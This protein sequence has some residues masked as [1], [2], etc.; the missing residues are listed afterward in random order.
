MPSSAAGP[1]AAGPTSSSSGLLHSRR[2]KGP[3]GMS[4]PNSISDLASMTQPFHLE[5]LTDSDGYDLYPSTGTDSSPELMLHS[6]SGRPRSKT[7]TF[8]SSPDVREFT[9]EEWEDEE[10]RRTS[11]D[12]IKSDASDEVEIWNGED[13]SLVMNSSVDIDDTS[14]QFLVLYLCLLLF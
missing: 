1:S 3:R 6:L 13:S 10:R 11:L 5:G 12:S 14:G 4:P 8:S 2:M 7:V 9:K